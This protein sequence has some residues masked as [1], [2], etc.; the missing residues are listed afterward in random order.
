ML[1]ALAKTYAASQ[2][3]LG[4]QVTTGLLLLGGATGLFFGGR[5]VWKRIQA[6]AREN[7]FSKDLFG[8]KQPKSSY[9]A[10]DRQ[11]A[12]SQAAGIYQA[13]HQNDI[14]GNWFGT[15]ATEDEERVLEVAK[16]VQHWDLVQ[17]AYRN[18]HGRVLHEDFV[19]HIEEPYFAQLQSII[20]NG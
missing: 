15:S 12:A 5:W 14:F 3:P 2:T 18:L 8:P 10:A 7:Q 19:K 1:P 20:R 16:Q 13:I 9:T 4:K 6:R 17:Q 11:Q